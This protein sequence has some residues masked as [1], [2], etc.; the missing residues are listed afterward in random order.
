[1]GIMGCGKSTIGKLLSQ[2][3]NMP[4]I[5]TD[6]WIVQDN[7]MPITTIFTQYGEA[8]FRSME[9]EVIYKIGRLTGYVVALGGGAVM[10]PENWECIHSSGLT[11]TLSYPVEVIEARIRK[12]RKRPLLNQK[13][14]R[15]RM[16]HIVQLLELRNPVYQKADLILHFNKEWPR[17]T[18][19][20]MITSIVG[21]I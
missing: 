14:D 2:T 21:S 13:S 12:N 20:S 15:D 4:F 19:A 5:D 11:I 1:M 10:D 3:M 9:K 8:A 18:V 7:D 16:K 17:E 6:T